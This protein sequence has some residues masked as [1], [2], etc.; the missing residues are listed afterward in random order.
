MKH[1][2]HSLR[3]T[4]ITN[5]FEVGTPPH[6]VQRWAGHAK[7]EQADTY[8]DLRE[9]KDFLQTWVVDYMVD[10]KARFVPNL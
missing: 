7:A 4:F 2:G 1:T 8:L 6:I 9:Q 10:L 5:A 3:H